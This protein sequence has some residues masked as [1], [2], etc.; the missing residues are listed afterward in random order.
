[1]FV[2]GAAGIGGGIFGE[3]APLPPSLVA[4]W[5]CGLSTSTHRAHGLESLA[6]DC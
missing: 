5:R 6:M 4:V 3:M 1:V 2:A